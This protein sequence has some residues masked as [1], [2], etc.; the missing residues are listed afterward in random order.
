MS[1][2]QW[3]RDARFGLFVHWG[4][5]SVLGRGE[6]VMYRERIPADEYAK[7]AD[8]FNP[9][10]FSMDS[11][12]RFAA[13]NGMKY[14]VFTTCHHEGFAMYDSKADPFNSMNAACHR[15]F[16]AEYVA[17]CRKYGLGVGLYYSLGDWRFGIV[18]ES[19]SFEKA[20]SMRDLTFAQVRELMSNYGKIDILW[21]DGG[22]CYPSTAADTAADVARFWHAEKLNAM[23]RSLQPDI[24]INN[25]SGTPEDFFI[26]EG[27][28]GTAAD[29]RCREACFTLGN[30]D[31]SH[32]GYFKN[33][34]LRKSKY[35]VMQMV[36]KTISGGQNLLLNV[37]P[38]P[39]GVIPD[40]QRKL[41][42][43]IGSWLNRYQEIAYR[44]YATG[45]SSDV[46]GHSGNEF[47]V[48]SENDEAV[49]CLLQN[50]P[51]E[52]MKIPVMNVEIERAELMNS[53][54]SIKWSRLESGIRLSG[55][56]AQPPDP[57][58]SVVKLIKKQQS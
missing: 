42:E 44:S 30:N 1:R 55:F 9:E 29:K 6:W 27:T 11:L 57:L 50:W 46:N 21:Y 54:A 32:W 25:R 26:S 10:N 5:Y 40:W 37:G 31:N 43:E 34:T 47:C 36:L 20:V 14:M 2:T 56:P 51:D 3:F 39:N 18:K 23:V 35:E 24:L 48:V 17:S 52:S 16:V 49:Y 58:C 33:E 22:W 12:C 8:R 45:V 53:D 19:D 15:D 13:E 28:M 7:L 41:V 4:L 38:D